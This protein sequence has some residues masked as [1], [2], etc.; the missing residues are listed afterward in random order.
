MEYLTKIATVVLIVFALVTFW[1]LVVFLLAGI[2]GVVAYTSWK[3]NKMMKESQT[4]QSFT[5]QRKQS[6]D[7]IEA[8][9]T[10]KEM[11]HE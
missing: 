4:V 6:S 1:P 2:A 9:Y 10:E 3:T 11:N 5:A 8:E 7:I